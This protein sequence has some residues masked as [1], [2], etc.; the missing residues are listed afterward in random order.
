MTAV[1]I[2][3]TGLF[4]PEHVITN[5]ELVESFNAYVDQE[6]A[7]NA[8]AIAAGERTAL[9][10]SSVEFIKK[11]SGI[12]R[13]YVLEKSGILDPQRMYP[14]FKERTDDELSMMAEIAV[15]AACQALEQAGKRG[16]DVD[17]V[18]CSASSLQRAYPAVAVE[19]Q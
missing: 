8:E 14:R 13:R 16:A 12:E 19:N 15:A 5:E 9:A 2:S 6:N 4:H 1:V 11:A 18:I 10:H 7:R 17:R 3:G